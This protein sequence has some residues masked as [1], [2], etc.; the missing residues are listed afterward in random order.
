MLEE[1]L[2]LL[3]PRL[4]GLYNPRHLLHTHAIGI[5]ET[6]PTGPAHLTTSDSD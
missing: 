1:E 6:F 2:L 3:S 4:Y 5:Q